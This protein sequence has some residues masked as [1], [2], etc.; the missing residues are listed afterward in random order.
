MIK[1]KPIADANP[2]PPPAAKAHRPSSLYRGNLWA[3]ALK[4]AGALPLRLAQALAVIGCQIYRI[5]SPRREIVYENLLPIFKNDGRAAR[6][7]TNRLFTR[8]AIKVVDLLRFEAG[9]NA[10]PRFGELT[11]WE[12][13]AHAYERGKGV[14]MI[15]PH[16]GNW[17]IGA[18]LLI[19]KNIKMFAVTQA[20]P[21]TNFTAQRSQARARW[22]IETIVV[23][24]DAFAFVEIIR[25]LQE[26]ATVALLIDRPARQSA[27]EAELFGRKFLASLAPAELARASGCAVVGGVIVEENSA[28]AAR[29]FPEFEY[30]RRALGS[31]EGRAAFTRQIMDAFA[32]SIRD[33]ADQWYHFIPIWP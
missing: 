13:F 28:Y 9:I 19:D 1:T 30:D 14:L 8:F 29:F 22:G 16:L 18:S 11:N 4:I 31:R 6:A 33:Y 23:G 3:L 32:P 7:A 10:R 26:G 5:V 2:S 12:N 20:E 17:E 15:T 24:Q 21:G 25:R 27:V